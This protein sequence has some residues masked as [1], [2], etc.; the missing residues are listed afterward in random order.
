MDPKP[1]RGCL[2][3]ND[4]RMLP[5]ILNPFSK[6]NA[7]EPG[8]LPGPQTGMA[9]GLSLNPPMLLLQHKHLMDIT[10]TC[11]AVME[12]NQPKRKYM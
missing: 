4:Y 7:F 9:A 2:S 1:T 3:G 5:P 6:F 11:Q 10:I 12:Q 8:E